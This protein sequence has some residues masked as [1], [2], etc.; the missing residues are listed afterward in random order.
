MKATTREGINGWTE[1]ILE[2]D[3]GMRLE[4]LTVGAVVTRLEVPN[5][6]GIAENIVMSLADQGEYPL[7]DAYFGSL[8]GP[9]AG[10]VQDAS[11]M[12]GG[13]IHQL[14]ANEGRHQLH[15]GRDGFHQ[16]EFVPT[17]F[18]AQNKVGVRL[19]RKEEKRVDEFPGVV[20]LEVIYT[21]TNQNEWILTYYAST[22]EMTPLTL[23]NHTYFNLSGQF[24][25]SVANHHVTMESDGFLELGED[26]LPTGFIL[27]EDGPFQLRNGRL[28]GDVFKATHEQL[29]GAGA[30]FDHF[31]FF[32]ED[33]KSIRV[34]EPISGRVM[35]M[36]TT[37]PGLVFY[38]GNGLDGSYTLADGT[39]A[40]KHHGFCLEA[41][42]SP[43]SLHHKGLPSIWV[44]PGE[45]YEHE[46]VY[47]FSTT[48]D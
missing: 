2:N 38:T 40:M 11:F 43:A 17:L 15:G 19:K 4:V 28:L 26:H 33:K 14:A 21:L 9:V 35:H 44:K 22:D 27:A 3:N 31:F 34:T 47:R 13:A 46:T 45:R 25:Q 37:Q 23:T 39:K 30:G 29:S 5:K 48:K 42:S 36:T 6:Q 7:N 8:I 24:D 41:Q 16:E 32:K 10:R 12:H 1:I 20:S 18:E